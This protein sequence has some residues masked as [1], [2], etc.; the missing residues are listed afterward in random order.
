VPGVQP[1]EVVGEDRPGEGVVQRFL[2]VVEGGEALHD[3]AQHRAVESVFRLSGH[4][5]KL[6]RQATGEREGTDSHGQDEFESCCETIHVPRMGGT[7]NPFLASGSFFSS[8]PSSRPKQA[9]DAN[10]PNLNRGGCGKRGED[11]TDDTR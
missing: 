6:D 4:R 1:P 3:A 5:Q 11:W 2:R 8:H 10:T 9:A 7:F